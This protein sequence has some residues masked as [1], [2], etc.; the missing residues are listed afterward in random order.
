MRSVRT[1]IAGVALVLAT[2]GGGLMLSQGAPAG[3]ESVQYTCAGTTNDLAVKW[4]QPSYGLT[5]NGSAF[6]K[7]YRNYSTGAFMSLLGQ[8]INAVSPGSFIV[9]PVLAGDVSIT[10]PSTVAP[11]GLVNPTL[12]ASI[13]LPDNLVSDAQHYLGLSSV[14]LQNSTIA[15]NGTQASPATIT[16]GIPNQTVPLV[17]GTTLQATATGPMTATG[18]SG[19]MA[20]SPG[21]AHVELII[22]PALYPSGKYITNITFNGV[23]I[24]TD[25]YVYGLRFDC[26]PSPVNLAYT[27]I[28]GGVTTT[29][30]PSTT[31]T[32][33]T[34]TT[35]STSTTTT[36]TSTTTTTA[37]TTTTSTTTTT[38][39]T[40]TTSTSTTTTTAP[41][42]TTSTS[43][44]TTTAPTTTTTA[45]TT[46]TTAPSTTTTTVPSGDADIATITV[47]G[48]GYANAGSL[49]SGNFVVKA[50]STTG[51]G[52][53]PGVNGGS[54]TVSVNVNQFL[55]WGFG[56]VTVSDPG[57]G[58]PST[59]GYVLFGPAPSRN[60]SG[61]GFT[62]VNGAV[63]SYTVSLRITDLG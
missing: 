51:G 24:S 50:G 23:N 48:Y 28:D 15:L 36:S 19:L 38:A 35:T 42:T 12:T 63:K 49:T 25:F 37:P 4:W 55:F 16:S 1:R 62:F 7:A 56:T 13:T 9:N 5:W 3:A 31:T 54:A 53:L 32:A 60:V 29:T 8:T 11:G 40:T 22:D 44:T 45:P 18:S 41:T 2:I 61:S 52:T 58:L 30:A 43:T 14:L 59:T 34:S 17:A 20:F 39:P 21:K 47:S 27:T 33:P 10:A 6:V 26:T 46:T 57:A